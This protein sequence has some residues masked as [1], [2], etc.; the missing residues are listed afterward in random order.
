[1][2]ESDIMLIDDDAD[3]R[4]AVRLALEFEG[5]DVALAAN[6]REAWDLLH[7]APPPALI[8][9][10]LMMPVMDGPQFLRLLRGDPELCALPVI[11]MTAF[12]TTS[13][14]ASLAGETQGCLGKPLGL[15]QL[16]DVASRHC[17]PRR[18]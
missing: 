5:Y 1:M 13:R 2:G 14:A 10:D 17:S 9:L 4:A 16:L 8:L 15:D 3:I 18:R 12:G 6:G 7:S 11:L